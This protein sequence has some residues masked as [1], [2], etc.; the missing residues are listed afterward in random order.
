MSQWLTHCCSDPHV[1]LVQLETSMSP[2]FLY[3]EAIRLMGAHGEEIV[4]SI[5]VDEL[6]SSS[7]KLQ[8]T[9]FSNRYPSPESSTQLAKTDM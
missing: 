9:K 4:R 8:Q 5:Y 7:G 2:R 3:D 1:D 6:V